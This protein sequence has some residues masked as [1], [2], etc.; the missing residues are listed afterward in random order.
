MQEKVYIQNQ[1]KANFNKKKI[2]KYYKNP[3]I[4]LTKNTF[5]YHPIY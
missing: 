5:K 2:M 3:K 4:F 1:L